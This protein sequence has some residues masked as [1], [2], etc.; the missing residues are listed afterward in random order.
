MI[1]G[2]S[3]G[4]SWRSRRDSNSRAVFYATYA[5]SRGAS[6][7]T[8]V[9]LHG[10]FLSRT[11]KMIVAERVGFEPTV[12]YAITSFQDWLLKPLGHLSIW[13]TSFLRKGSVMFTGTIYI[14]PRR[15]SFVKHFLK[16]FDI[17]FIGMFCYPFCYKLPITASDLSIT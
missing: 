11:I 2:F 6:S 12:A 13:N 9:L 1:T 14:I 5:L 15:G 16:L 10:T 3:A 17:N 4:Q 8:W 7:P